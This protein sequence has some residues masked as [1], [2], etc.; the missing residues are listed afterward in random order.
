MT[1]SPS[2]AYLGC[3]IPADKGKTFVQLIDIDGKVLASAFGFDHD[4]AVTQAMRIAGVAGITERPGRVPRRVQQPAAAPQPAAQ[5][6]EQQLAFN[7]DPHALRERPA[8]LL[9]ACQQLSLAV[10]G[11]IGAIRAQTRP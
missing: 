11:L 6:P 10:D 4:E 3:S 2:E 8:G 9:A 1:S 5:P 7:L